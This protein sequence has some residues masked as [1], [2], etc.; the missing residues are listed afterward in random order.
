M[1][2]RD[3]LITIY[4]SLGSNLGDRLNN[5]K[6]AGRQVEMYIGEPLKQSGI[7]ESSAWGYASEYLFYNCCLSLQTALEP[8]TLLDR[9][10]EIEK[11]MGR[12]RVR[13]GYADRSIDI[14]LL[15]YG[16]LILEHPRLI[17]PHPSMGNRRFVLAPLAEIA[18]G[19]VHP[20]E[21]I[22]ITEMLRRCRDKGKVK[23]I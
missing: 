11:Q 21:G 22:T 2:E 13:E 23:V 7:Y 9:I 5:L 3:E 1:K 17:L 12:L 14:D 18:P 6:A 8:L 20:V 10:L 4:L 16:D 19:L 15:I